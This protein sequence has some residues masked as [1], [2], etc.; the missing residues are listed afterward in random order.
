[1][2]PLLAILCLCALA[3]CETAPPLHPRVLL[4]DPEG[5]Y[6]LDLLNLRTDQAPP[7]FPHRA[8]KPKPEKYIP[9]VRDFGGPHGKE[10][11]LY[12]PAQRAP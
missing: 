10:T 2:K 3:A 12:S 11:W 9:I 5:A 1:M 6:I 7:A 4:T 8:P